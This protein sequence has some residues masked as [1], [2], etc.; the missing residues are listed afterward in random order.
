M[1]E[2]NILVA[3][4]YISSIIIITSGLY[5]YP[6]EQDFHIIYYLLMVCIAT[7]I[8]NHSATKHKRFFQFIDRFAIR[9]SALIYMMITT[10]MSDVKN[11]HIVKYGAIIS[12]IL[13]LVSSELKILKPHYPKNIRKIPHAM[14][15]ILT[16]VATMFI[17]LDL[18]EGL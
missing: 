10:Q 1:T 18:R 15:H 2:P 3:S 7:S 4:V 6:L 8:M 12:S 13:Y 11:K 5:Y 17:F 14:A 16:A 9:V